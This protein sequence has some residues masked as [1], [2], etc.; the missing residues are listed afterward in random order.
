MLWT[1]GAA[2]AESLL[3]AITAAGP[4]SGHGLAYIDPSAGGQL[5]Q[6][7]AVV[8]TAVSGGLFFFSRHI[9]ATAARVKRFIVERRPRDPGPG[10]R[11]S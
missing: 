6:L 7:L 4:S 2:L 10:G 11:R 8:F 1:R 3:L 9:R 5:F